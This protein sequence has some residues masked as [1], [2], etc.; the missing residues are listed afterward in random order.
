MN[1]KVFVKEGSSFRSLDVPLDVVR[2]L[3]R[4]R[5]IDL[6]EERIKKYGRPVKSTNDFP[7]GSV[8]LDFDIRTAWS[9]NAPLKLEHLEPT[10]KI[11]SENVTLK[12][13]SQ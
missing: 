13:Y 7:T 1:I 8:V 2:D 5:L 9:Y 6:D 11:V 10:W 3:L 4:D 12:K